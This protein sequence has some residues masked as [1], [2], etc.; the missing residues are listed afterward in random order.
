MATVDVD[1]FDEDA[2]FDQ[3][4]PREIERHIRAASHLI[5][6]AVLQVRAEDGVIVEAVGRPENPNAERAL[7]QR[8]PPVRNDN[9]RCVVADEELVIARF[10]RGF[11]QRRFPGDEGQGGRLPPR[12]VVTDLCLHVAKPEAQSFIAQSIDEQIQVALSD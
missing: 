9:R 5:V 3:H 7:L 1:V 10:L 4:R 11:F 6:V 2:R 12:E 8:S